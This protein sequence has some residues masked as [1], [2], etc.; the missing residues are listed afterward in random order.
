MKPVKR[1]FCTIRQIFE[2]SDEAAIPATLAAARAAH[3]ASMRDAGFATRLYNKTETL[4]A[5]RE[6]SEQ[7]V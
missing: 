7:L 3:E 6:A 2:A 5:A 1:P 4:E